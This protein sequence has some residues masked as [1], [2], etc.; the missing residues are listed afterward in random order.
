[1]ELEN[2]DLGRKS[3]RLERKKYRTSWQNSSLQS[4]KKKK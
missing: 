1:M 3:E 4:K 2:V